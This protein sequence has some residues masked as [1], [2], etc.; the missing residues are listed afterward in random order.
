MADIPRTLISSLWLTPSAG[1]MV[2]TIGKFK[3]ALDADLVSFTELE[4][5]RSE[6]TGVPGALHI[7]ITD[8]LVGRMLAWAPKAD[9]A[10]AEALADQA[11]LFSCHS[12]WRYH[13]S[14]TIEQVTRRPRPYWVVP[15]GVLDPWVFTYNRLYKRI[16]MSTVGNGLLRGASHVIFSTERERAKAAHVYRS[17]RGVVIPWPVEP[18][19]ILHREQTRQA[20]RARLGIP[21]QDRILLFLGRLHPLKRPLETIAAVAGAGTGNV[22]LVMAGPEHGV[23]QAQCRQLAA[24]LRFPRLHMIGRVSG[25][26]LREC[27]AGADGV[28]LLSHRENFGHAAAEAV[29]AGLPVILSH[30]VDLNESLQPLRCGWFVDGDHRQSIE[31]AVA[32]FAAVP[33][34]Q[35]KEIAVPASRWVRTALTFDLFASRLRRLATETVL[36]HRERRRIAQARGITTAKPRVWFVYANS[37]SH[38]GQWE[39]SRQIYDAFTHEGVDV[40]HLVM[41]SLARNLTGLRRWGPYIGELLVAWLRFLRLYAEHKQLVHFNMGQTWSSLFRDG[42]PLIAIMAGHRDLRLAVSL[43]GSNFMEWDPTLI[44]ATLMRLMLRR[45]HVVSVLGPNQLNRMISMGVPREKVRVVDNTCGAVVLSPEAVVAKHRGP[46][47]LLHLS[48]LIDTKGYPTYLRALER[49]GAQSGPELSAVLCGRITQTA[50][51]DRIVAEAVTREWIFDSV[52]RINRSRRVRAQWI[53]GADGEEK[54]TLLRET[55][56]F[57]FPSRY[58]VEAQPIVLIEAMAHGCAIITSAVGE[59]PAMFAGA[60]AAV[61]LSEP[62][63]EAVAQS[64]EQLVND[65]VRRRELGLNA[66]QLYLERFSPERYLATWRELLLAQS[67][68]EELGR[69]TVI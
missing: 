62:T 13:A 68:P 53:Q 22:H 18:I 12:I 63:E 5:L 36:E 21:A 58:R 3:Q 44:R 11:E 60:D 26:G 42:M 66:R 37:G 30:G 1:G 41:P 29:S 45:A 7:P 19:E 61:I 23:T 24:K 20:F 25:E 8:R 38:S 10:K 55:G 27:F 39:A 16:W 4:K 51:S 32:E 46:V 35:L 14:W 28:I 59:I 6:G 34:A 56:I 15:H 52:A 47:R 9:R 67:G 64:I 54:W 50:F 40:R 2:K 43:H 17:P 57:V 69:D 48:A 49:L 31:Q 65:P 33:A